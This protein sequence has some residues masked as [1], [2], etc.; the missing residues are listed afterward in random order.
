MSVQFICILQHKHKQ[1]NNIKQ[2]RL[3][4]RVLV[5]ESS[6]FWTAKKGCHGDFHAK[7][8]GGTFD[9]ESFDLSH[10]APG[11]S[12]GRCNSPW[13]TNRPARPL[14]HGKP[15]AQH[16][17]PGPEKEGHIIVKGGIPIQWLKVVEST[18]K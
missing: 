16:Q 4:H 1:Y 13:F 14:E 15:R 9:D 2:I 17:Q 3:L 6:I 11:R 8:W 10:D 7:I 12:L 5:I 18:N